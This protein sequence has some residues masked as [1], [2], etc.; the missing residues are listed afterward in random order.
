MLGKLY[1]YADLDSLLLLYSQERHDST[2]LG[3]FLEAFAKQRKEALNL[4][5]QQVSG[6]QT[7]QVK[8]DLGAIC[9]RADLR[10]VDRGLQASLISRCCWV[11]T[12]HTVRHSRLRAAVQFLQRNFTKPT[13]E[14]VERGVL[15][16]HTFPEA[17]H[18]FVDLPR[19]DIAPMEV[20]VSGD[21]HTYAYGDLFEVVF[22]R[23]QDQPG[24]W[25][26]TVAPRKDRL[27]GRFAGLQSSLPQVSR[28]NVP[29]TTHKGAPF[30]R[31]SDSLGDWTVRFKPSRPLMF[32]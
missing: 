3:L 30:C 29:L 8:E 31:Y 14:T 20:T 13:L 4:L 16:Q 10:K 18:L 27:Q 21:C 9:L 12:G 15:L 7:V 1:R 26:Y 25:T 17:F 23:R 2:P 32:A 19:M 28:L 22:Q 11:L 24:A 5:L 6:S